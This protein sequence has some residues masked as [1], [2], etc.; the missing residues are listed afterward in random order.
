MSKGEK[1]GLGSGMRLIQCLLRVDPGDQSLCEN[2]ILRYT[3]EE[4]M[5]SR[6]VI[7]I[8]VQQ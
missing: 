2:P 3:G 1:Y 6:A 5:H 8:K 7:D 4:G